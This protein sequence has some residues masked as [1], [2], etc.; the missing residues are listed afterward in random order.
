MGNQ[1]N[2]RYVWMENYMQALKSFM[3]DM[4]SEEQQQETKASEMDID[5]IGYSNE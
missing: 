2:N 5:Q 4:V 1:F 3:R